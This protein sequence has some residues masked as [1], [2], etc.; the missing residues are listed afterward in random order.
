MSSLNAGGV[1]ITLSAMLDKLRSD[2]RQAKS[3]YMQ[4]KGDIEKN[5]PNIGT[6]GGRVGG[7]ASSPN[8][9]GT[10]NG[11]VTVR[12]PSGNPEADAARARQ[13]QAQAQQQAAVAAA[14]GGGSGGGAGGGPNMS[15]G[16]AGWT[17][18]NPGGAS[19]S[20][21]GG[22][23]GGGGGRGGN[24]RL[25]YMARLAARSLVVTQIASAIGNEFENEENYKQ[26][27]RLAGVDSAAQ[28]Q[29]VLGHSKG[30]FNAIPLVGGLAWKLYNGVSGAFGL[31]EQSINADLEMSQR[32]S[33]FYSAIGESAYQT[34]QTRNRTRSIAYGPNQY[35]RAAFEA[36]AA[37]SNSRYATSAMTTDLYR[38]ATATVSGDADDVSQLPSS[39]RGWDTLLPFNF[40]ARNQDVENYNASLEKQREEARR[41]AAAQNLARNKADDAE[42]KQTL[43]EQG[44][45]AAYQTAG[46]KNQADLLSAQNS[47]RPIA[48][49]AKYIGDSLKNAFYRY[50]Q[51]DRNSQDTNLLIAQA[52]L[53]QQTLGSVQRDLNDQIYHGNTVNLS[54]SLSPMGF[55]DSRTENTS[56]AQDS[57]AD[58][59]K[60]L[61]DILAALKEPPKANDH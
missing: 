38:R 26:A 43:L 2:L 46:V 61:S 37:R 20:P 39:A 24:P 31:S 12:T 32:E 34:Q 56:T 48:G 42:L 3:E 35:G 60:I 41:M 22:G 21:G 14:Q 45:D 58:T 36:N 13:A 54:S 19:P 40:P 4:W 23:G 16:G 25:W 30:A 53:A 17:W 28:S 1:T 47:Y 33:G 18:A 57:I 49:Q 9:Q 5:P 55:Y 27:L 11:D 10:S 15:P 50:N 44:Y 51:G 52:G 8:F 6:G 29:A 7:G 59:N